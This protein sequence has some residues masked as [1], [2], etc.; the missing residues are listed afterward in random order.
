MTPA[1]G[2]GFLHML[3]DTCNAGLCTPDCNSKIAVKI[4]G[5]N[6]LFLQ[7]SALGG[8]AE[9]NKLHTQYYYL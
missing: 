8:M 5:A 2:P 3:T 7:Y 1:S 9:V 4:L 6:M